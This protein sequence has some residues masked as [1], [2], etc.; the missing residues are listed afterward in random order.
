MNLIEAIRS[1]LQQHPA[2]L[3]PAQ[4]VEVMKR[5]MPHLYNTPRHRESLAKKTVT[6][7]DH[8]LK[9]DI[10]FLYPKVEGVEADKTVKPMRL[11]WAGGKNTPADRTSL[12]PALTPEDTEVP[13]MTPETVAKLELGIGTLYVLGTQT[14]TKDGFEIVKIGITAGSV[15]QRIKQLFN[16]SAALPFRVILQ[17]ETGNYA[18]LEKALHHLLDPFR[19]HSAREY[20]SDQ[21]LPFV[22]EVLRIHSAIQAAFR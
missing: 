5:E 6:S 11:Y 4:M 3:S 9:A 10:Y 19:I 7:L 22:D 21:C 8:A 13:V 17:Q 1:V 18:E 12:T 15:E 14:Y 2:G 20:F 16:T